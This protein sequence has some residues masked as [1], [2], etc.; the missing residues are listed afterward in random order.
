MPSCPLSAAVP[1]PPPTLKAVGAFHRSDGG[2]PAR[3]GDGVPGAWKPRRQNWGK[4][5]VAN[6]VVVVVL[7]QATT[8]LL[9]AAVAL[10]VPDGPDLDPAV[11]GRSPAQESRG[12]GLGDT[13]VKGGWRPVYNRGV[14]QG[15]ALLGGGRHMKTITGPRWRVG[16]AHQRKGRGP[17]RGEG[18][19]DDAIG[20]GV[21]WGGEVGHG[22]TRSWSRWACFDRLN[23]R[24]PNTFRLDF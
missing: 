12:G 15:H 2:G 5:A 22:L 20:I 13:V 7:L 21:P 4:A 6:A 8:T 18:E 17:Q 3:G 9:V 24:L 10:F 1:P 23:R 14:D 11:L 19:I 16:R